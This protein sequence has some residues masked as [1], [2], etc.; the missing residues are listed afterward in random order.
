MTR[1]LVRV[2]TAFV[3][4]M[5]N[6]IQLAK[7]RKE[8][9]AAKEKSGWHHKAWRQ[10][11]SV[12]TCNRALFIFSE[13]N[14]VRRLARKII[15]WPPFE[16]TILLTIMCTTVVLALEEHLPNND[17][18]ILS[19]SLVSWVRISFWSRPS[20]PSEFLPNYKYLKIRLV[21]TRDGW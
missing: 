13:D 10:F 5:L 18:T 20:L 7:S 15:E 19:K 2:W 12:L 11:K 3:G 4:K 1:S 6:V 8:E 9:E 14:F 16:W 21:Y 17:K